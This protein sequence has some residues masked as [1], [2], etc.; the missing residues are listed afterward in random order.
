[1]WIARGALEARPSVAVAVAADAGHRLLAKDDTR[2]V[3]P[4]RAANE[5]NMLKAFP[6]LN[7]E[8]LRMPFSALRPRSWRSWLARRSSRRGGVN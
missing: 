3:E 2:I 6:H 8:G 7:W 4:V 5:T 1:M